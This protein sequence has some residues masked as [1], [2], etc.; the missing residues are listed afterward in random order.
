[1]THKILNILKVV[2]FLLPV[3]GIEAQVTNNSDILKDY[4]QKKHAINHDGMIVLTSWASVNI[5]SGAGYF[6]S[7][8]K[9][10]QYF[11]AMN[12]AWGA[13]NMAIAVPGL[14]SNK[15]AYYSKSELL[16]DQLKTEKVFLVNAALDVIYI[17]GGFVLKE[18]SK[19]QSD[20]DHVAMFSGFG[21]S[22]LV[23]GVGLL[24]FDINMY[25]LNRSHRKKHLMPIMKD[26]QISMNTKGFQIRFLF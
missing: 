25:L 11:F 4:V 12:A 13:V 18:V 16:K 8:S 9:H 6:T 2:A 3:A 1:M 23:Q 17:G 24:V 22:F 14:L 21:D 26:A 15:K 7:T 5:L 10:D 19:N 20:K